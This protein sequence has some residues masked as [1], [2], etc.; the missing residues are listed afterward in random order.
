MTDAKK[1][2]DSDLAAAL[3]RLYAPG[4]AVYALRVGTGYEPAANSQT[5]AKLSLTHEAVEAHLSNEQPIGIYTIAPG[6]DVCHFGVLDFDDHDGNSGWDTIRSK[7][8]E[9]ARAL[10]REDLPHLAF[11]SG[12]GKGIHL[13]IPFDGPV[14]AAALRAKLRAVLGR[15]GLKSGTAGVEKDEV[16]IFPKQDRVAIGGL[17]NLIALPLARQS[18]LLDAELKEFKG[19]V[20]AHLRN[21][22]RNP[23]S[24]IPAVRIDDPTELP[25][26]ADIE[27]ELPDP[28][29]HPLMQCQFMQHSVTNAKGIAE[30]LWLAA[31]TNA[32]RAPQGRAFFHHLSKHDPARYD[33]DE[34]DKKFEHAQALQPYS[35]SKLVDHGYTCPKMKADGTCTITGGRNPT[36]FVI[37]VSKIIESLRREKHADVKNRRIG[38]V[39]KSRLIQDGAFFVSKADQE[40]LYF[41]RGEKRLY[42]LGSDAFA[43]YLCDKF[44]LNSA[45]QEFNF[46]V[47]DI[48]TH[49]LR[50]GAVQEVHRF[51]R[52]TGNALYI[53]VGAQQMYRLDG[54]AITLLSNGD[55][56][57]LFRESDQIE[58][59]VFNPD[60]GSSHVKLHLVEQLHTNDA[61]SKALFQVYIHALFFERLLPTKPIVLI[62]GEKGSGKTSVGRAIKKV[63]FGTGANVDIGVSTDERSA[64]AAV[65]HNYF[66][67]MDNVDGMVDWLGNLLASVSTGATIRMAT[68]Y[69]TNEESKFEPH[70]FVMINS[71]DPASL[72]RDDIADRLLIF[73]AERHTKFVPESQLLAD[74]AKNRSAILSEMLVNLNRIV[75]TLKRRKNVAPAA[76][77]LADFAALAST[78]AKVLKLPGAVRAIN[79]MENKRNDLVLDGDPITSAL[80]AYSIEPDRPEWIATGALF[81]ALRPGK[82]FGRTTGRSFGRRLRNLKSNLAETFT[83]EFRSGRSNTTEV[84]LMLTDKAHA[85]QA[86]RLGLK[87]LPG[88]SWLKS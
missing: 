54:K 18:V 15:H 3:Y 12:G 4:T 32:A 73:E 81:A 19:D 9:V 72:R 69:K 26:P 66:I 29:Q 80:L 67:C 6:A 11:R 68:L 46:V 40:Q 34:T 16:E 52:F 51:A 37:P 76:Q 61:D 70:C 21:F 79:K 2:P 13:V 30:P 65:S 74:L 86:K 75:A 85:A 33:R 63:L 56:G 60:V 77:R 22:A 5:K 41:A 28:E 59:W 38:M 24:R 42:K 35:C 23:A 44:G 82:E 78:I 27:G 14:N 87:V 36:S 1:R 43:A 49:G 47:A 31:A 57:V 17:G 20:L 83:M 55:D 71:R 39:V 53:D 88:P 7:A 50:H 8:L 62:T 45:E 25:A 84:K 48:E 64:R 10:E 58:P